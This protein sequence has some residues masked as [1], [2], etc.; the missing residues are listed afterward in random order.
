MSTRAIIT[1]F[2]KKDGFNI[3]IHWDGWVASVTRSIEI[4]FKYTWELPRFEAGDF[5]T[6]L[7]KV[8]KQRAWWVYLV[9][10]VQNM[11]EIDY[12]YQI[13]EDEWNVKVKITDIKH[14]KQFVHIH[15]A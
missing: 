9:T 10:A 7:I 2:D 13:S 15:R 1:I 5:A 11:S 14:K 12:F 8:L 4:A 6:A 3:Y